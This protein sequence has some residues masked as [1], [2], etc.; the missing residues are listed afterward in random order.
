MLGQYVLNG[1]ASTA[2]NSP[3]RKMNYYILAA[4]AM[5]ARFQFVWAATRYIPPNP[6]DFWDFGWTLN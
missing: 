1:Y 2:W 5:L 4:H 6:Q 3:Q